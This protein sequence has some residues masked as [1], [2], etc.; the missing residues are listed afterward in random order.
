MPT[1]SDTGAG[2]LA[3]CLPLRTRK[4]TRPR[5]LIM[6]DRT[7]VKGM[8]LH[9]RGDSARLWPPVLL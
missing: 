1:R 4:M 5:P 8:N 9:M 3:P 6:E 7:D 2:G